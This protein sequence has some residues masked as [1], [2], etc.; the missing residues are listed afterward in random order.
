MGLMIPALMGGKLACPERPMAGIGADGSSL[1]RLG[2]LEVFSRMRIAAPMII[3][4]DRC[5]GT[6][7]SRQKSRGLPAYG[8][9]TA[10]VDFSG[11]ARACGLNAVKVE[12]PEKFRSALAKAMRADRATVIEA[13]VDPEAYRDSFGPTTGN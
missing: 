8:L 9:D 4:N 13:I 2:E 10:S 3:V 5:L 6:I 1:M 7:K 12:S 11:I